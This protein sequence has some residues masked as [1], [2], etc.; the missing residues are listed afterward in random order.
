MSDKE[1]F[2]FL[3]SL[4]KYG[5][6]DKD[7]LLMTRAD[8]ERLYDLK[9]QKCPHTLW[10]NTDI[11]KHKIILM[12]H[13]D[14]W[15]WKGILNPVVIT[16]IKLIPEIKSKYPQT[17]LNLIEL[18]QKKYPA[19][20]KSVKHIG[21]CAFCQ[22]NLCLKKIV[23]V[24]CGHVFHEDCFEDPRNDKWRDSCAICCSKIDYAS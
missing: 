20:E 24:S 4:H 5:F 6:N 10:A 21:F 23:E 12:M 2:L 3:Q 22:E 8:I 1:V 18:A 11:E 13:N 15:P 7:I 14:G 17:Y 9:R 16:K 19:K